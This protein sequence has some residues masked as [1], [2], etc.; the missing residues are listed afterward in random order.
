MLLRQG[1]VLLIA[2][3][4]KPTCA[5]TPRPAD[6]GR[7]ILAY[8]EVT[9]HAHA[10]DA[11]LAELFEDRAGGLFL[12]ASAGAALAHEEHGTIQVA[13]GW[14]EIRRQREYSPTEL[15]QVAD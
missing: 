6:R 10:L 11:A 15:R 9:G 3:A 2:R 14:Y 4:A 7:V 13:P 1:D 12:R 5:L 8:G